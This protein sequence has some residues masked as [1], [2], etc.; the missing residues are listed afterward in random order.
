MVVDQCGFKNHVQIL[1]Q[2]QILQK[3][4]EYC[5]ELH[6]ILVEVR[7]QLSNQKP[8]ILRNTEKISEKVIKLV[9]EC[10]SNTK[11][12]VSIQNLIWKEFKIK[13][14]LKEGDALLFDLIMER[15]TNENT[16]KPR[17]TDHHKF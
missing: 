17:N 3:H 8:I 14:G 13:N 11:A 10:Q 1:T 6:Q 4:Y 7:W 5:I 15:F 16:A 2:K 12:I 9:K